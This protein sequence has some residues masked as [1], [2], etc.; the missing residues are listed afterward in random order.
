MK[1]INTIEVSPFDYAINEYKSPNGSSKDLPEEWDEF[2]KK[3]LSDKNIKNLESIKKGSFLVDITSI[4][5][6]ELEVIIK[7]EL[8][9][10]DLKDYEEQIGRICGGIA[11][12]IGNEFLIEP[13]CCGDIG[14]IQEWQ[15]IFEDGNDNWQELWIGHPWVFYKKTGGEIEFSD[16]Y[17][18]N[19]ENLQEVKSILKVQGSE[20][21]EKLKIIKEEQVEFEN[22]IRVIL[23]KM[24]IEHSKQIA[25]LMTGNE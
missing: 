15:S 25:K 7:N 1:L 13:T 4:K 3:C 23:K 5:L 17:E 18:S 22:K 9:D 21:K 24:E 6:F 11:I 14:N 10:I 20:L 16:Y 8:K 2:W 12:K 19:L